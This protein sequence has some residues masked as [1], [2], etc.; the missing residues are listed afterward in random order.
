MMLSISVMEGNW[1]GSHTSDIGAV[2]RS[3]V[4]CFNG[5]IVERPIEAIQVEPTL[6]ND[7]SP[8]TAYERTTSGHVRILLNARGNLWA[9]LAFQF[10]HELCHVMANFRPPNDHPSKWIEECLCEAS[11]LY[12]LCTMSCSWQ[13]FPPYP[14]WQSYSIKLLEYMDDRCKKPEH[15]LPIG[16]KFSEWLASKLPLLQRDA[17]R[18][19]DNTIVAQRILPIF[20]QNSTAWNAVRYLNLWDASQDLSIEQF[21]VHWRTACP[22]HLHYVPYSIQQRLTQD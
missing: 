17:G 21:C 4:Q 14:N 16:S 10:A 2:A 19:A 18:R 8:L 5:A 15:Q 3:V 20:E 11:S 22:P 7:D 1:G 9:R 12:A 13:T 6:K